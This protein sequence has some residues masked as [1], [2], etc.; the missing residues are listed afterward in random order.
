MFEP[1]SILA[2]PSNG[3]FV[4]NGPRIS[5]TCVV[6]GSPVPTLLWTQAGEEIMADNTTNIY[7]ENVVD[8]DGDFLVIS[9]L[10]MC[11]EVFLRGGG[12][13]ECSTWNGVEDELEERVQSVNFT[14]DPRSES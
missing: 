14:I 6:Y 10:E 5:A 9:T 7:T 2:A 12:V 13:T 11:E 4:S 8:P 3:Q 1:A